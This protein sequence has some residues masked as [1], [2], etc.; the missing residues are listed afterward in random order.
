MARRPSDDTEA[1]RRRATDRKRRS[2]KK[3]KAGFE[4]YRFYLPTKII[5]EALRIRNELPEDV[6]PTRKQIERDLTEVI[7]DWWAKRWLR[8]RHL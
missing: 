8:L 5:V 1:K 3:R 6:V 7:I 4:S 2:R